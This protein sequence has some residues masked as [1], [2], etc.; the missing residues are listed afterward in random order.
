MN[1]GHE[2]SMTTIH[3]NSPRDA[4]TR[5]EHML[6]MAGVTADVRTIRQQI[7]AALS[8]VIQV[9]RLSDG[10]RK[11]MSVQEI[12]GMEGDMLTMQEI[13]RF[14]QTGLSSTGRVQ[15]RFVA[16]G[17]RPRVMDRLKARGVVLRPDVFTPL[18][19]QGA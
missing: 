8:V 14:D 10:Q 17:I 2:G 1:T 11:V 18:Q 12:L 9:S 15:G 19:E 7:S 5:L 3:A 6:G 13:F 4:M 16:T